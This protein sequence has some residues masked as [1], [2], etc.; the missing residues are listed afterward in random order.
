MPLLS[1][2][3]RHNT[4]LHPNW[5]ERCLGSARLDLTRHAPA[6]EGRAGRACTSALNG[7]AA[8]RRFPSVAC[9]QPGQ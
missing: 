9:A 2:C 6:D 8:I 5:I 7:P 1:L 3:L 4:N